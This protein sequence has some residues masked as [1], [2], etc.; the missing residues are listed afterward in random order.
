MMRRMRGGTMTRKMIV[1]KLAGSNRVMGEGK[2]MWRK[3]LNDKKILFHC[4]FSKI[5]QN[6]DTKTII[7][8][9][10]TAKLLR[11]VPRYQQ[12]SQKN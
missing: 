11:I 4:K 1:M 9:R 8:L 3:N 12:Q 6:Y 7:V 5:S 10:R 2:R